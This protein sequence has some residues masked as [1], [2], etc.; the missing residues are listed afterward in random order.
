MN[1]PSRTRTRTDEPDAGDGRNQSPP[2]LSNNDLTTVQDLKGGRLS[3]A[4]ILRRVHRP[5]SVPGPGRPAASDPPPDAG[6]KPP[7][8][9][10]A[11]AAAVTPSP[12]VSE[13]CL[14]GLVAASE[15]SGDYGY[16]AASADCDGG[17][18]GG[19]G[20]GDDGDDEPE[21]LDG[22]SQPTKPWLSR[23]R[24][25]LVTF[26][27]FVGPGFMV[28][29]AYSMWAL[30]LSLPLS[31]FLC[32]FVPFFCLACPEEMRARLVG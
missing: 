15:L 29:V 7:A 6:D 27:K 32:L 5:G 9:T 16:P 17:G 23:V 26:G 22:A 2:L 8:T 20:G 19:G 31:L 28:A 1:R 25:A 12:A 3:N 30:S 11:A 24:H 18:G 4:R 10:A 21:G 13:A 14:V